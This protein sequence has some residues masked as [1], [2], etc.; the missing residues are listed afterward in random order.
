MFFRGG[1][2]FKMFKKDQKN[3]ETAILVTKDSFDIFY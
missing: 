1:V 3:E 2:M